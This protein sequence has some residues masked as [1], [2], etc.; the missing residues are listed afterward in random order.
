MLVCMRTTI[1]L[2]PHLL[3]D[4]K[5]HAAN[6]HRTLTAYIEDALRE[7]L[8]R[9]RAEREPIDLPISTRTGGA[10]PGVDL[11]KTSALLDPLE[12][13]RDPS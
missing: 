13:Y 10:M 12:K 4:A 2:D 5:K 1:R 6:T 9:S 11:I 3:R 8:A 7:V